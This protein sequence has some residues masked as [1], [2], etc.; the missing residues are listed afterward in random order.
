MVVLRLESI[1]KTLEHISPALRLN[2]LKVISYQSK[3]TE[4]LPHFQLSAFIVIKINTIHFYRVLYYARDGFKEI[5][6]LYI[7]Y[8][9]AIF[10]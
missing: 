4:T 5:Q 3:T 8:F 9:R 1:L 6:E 2:Q 10:N 7:V